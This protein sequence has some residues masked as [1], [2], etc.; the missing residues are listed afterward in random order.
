MHVEDQ[1]F[2]NVFGWTFSDSFREEWISHRIHIV[3]ISCSQLPARSGIFCLLV[4]IAYW[5][6][7]WKFVYTAINLAFWGI[8]V[9]VKLLAKFFLHGFWMI[10]SP[11]KS[12]CKIF[13]LSYPRH[14]NREL[15]IVIV[16]FFSSLKQK[17]TEPYFRRIIRSHVGPIHIEHSYTCLLNLNLLHTRIIK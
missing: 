1:V 4:E 7:A 12:W 10:L 14:C 3:T 13:F 17:G 15:I 8:I 2:V 6:W 5:P 9:K 11:N 16:Y